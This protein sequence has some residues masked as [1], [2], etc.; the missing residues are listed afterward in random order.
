MAQLAGII[1]T[2]GRATRRAPGLVGLLALLAATGPVAGQV[3]D[4]VPRPFVEGGAFDKPYLFNLAGRAA[5]GGY[6]DAQARY[7]RVE[8]AND[9]SG[10]ELK[11]FNLF[12]A[13]QISDFVRFGAELEFEEGGEEV[14]LEFAT[15]DLTLHP[16]FA[17]R[18]GMILAPLGRFN[19]A[20]DSPRNEFTDRPLVSTEILGVALS[21]AG[22]GVL[23][24]VPVGRGRVTYEAYA[25]NGFNDGLLV[26]S[27]EGTRVPL[28]KGNFEDNNASPA[29]VARVAWSPVRGYEVGVSG[30]H[31]R[32]NVWEPEGVRVD[33]PRSVSL[34]VGDVDVRPWGFRVSG[35][36]AWAT[37]DIPPALTETF[38]SRQR[39][40]YVDVLRDFGTGWIP[41]MP[42]SYFT[43]GLRLDHVD[44]DTDVPG[45][46]VEQITLGLNFHPTSD[47][48]FKLDYV[49]GRSFDAFNNRADHAAVLFGVATYF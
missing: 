24:A 27:P 49:R 5:F 44:F 19:L 40:F 15:V 45:D 6:A 21:E 22:F 17:F 2:N 29:A 7:R 20:H 18:A 25:V 8:G 4:T 39:G 11:R 31:G 34:W 3:P 12:T 46:A 26:R 30:H 35:E 41:T 10:F 32:Y 23:G 48:A 42:S 47:T 14:K 33:D 37:V 28:G 1:R 16:S 13:A 43:A 9:E 36:A 38:A